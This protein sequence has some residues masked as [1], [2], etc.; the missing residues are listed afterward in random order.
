MQKKKREFRLSL[1]L[2]SRKNA[3]RVKLYLNED[4][5]G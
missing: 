4:L 5:L 3:I 1:F 2:I